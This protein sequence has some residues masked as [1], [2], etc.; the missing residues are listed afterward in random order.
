MINSITTIK[1]KTKVKNKNSF[2]K[3]NKP[4]S[5][6]ED[7]SRTITGNSLRNKYRDLIY[8]YQSEIDS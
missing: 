4:L 1:L 6:S 7:P 5:L 2:L 3:E 8:E